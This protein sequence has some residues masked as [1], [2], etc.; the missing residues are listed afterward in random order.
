MFRATHHPPS[1]IQKLQLQPLVL[2]TFLIAG[3]CDGSAITATGN[4]KRILNQRLQL[5]FL[6]S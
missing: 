5:K 4:Q 3:G 1:G 6:N 2:C